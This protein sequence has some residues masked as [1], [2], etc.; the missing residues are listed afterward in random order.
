[1]NGLSLYVLANEYQAAANQLA[2]LDLPAE[3]VADTLEGMT[4]SIEE[5]SVN[6]AMFIR[7]LESSAEQ[8][9]AAE[10][11]MAKRRKAVENRAASVCRYLFDNMIRCGITKIDSPY[12]NLAIRDNPESVV[13]DNA[14]ELPK[15]YLTQPAPPAPAPDKKAIKDAIKAGVVVPGAHI[16]RGQRLEIK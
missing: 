14:D 10:N 16:E 13:I 3:V 12:F 9:K 5:K 1:M 7:N 15:E 8:M 6:V 2:D 4:G 11:E